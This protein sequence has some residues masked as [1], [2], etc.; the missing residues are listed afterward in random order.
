MKPSV[1][2]YSFGGYT[3]PEMLGVLG[4]MDKAKEL[5]FD[6]FEILDRYFDG[7][8]VTY[9]DVVRHSEKIGL[10]L[11]AYITGAEFLKSDGQG[12]EEQVEALKKH[13]DR[14]AEMGIHLLRH[15]VTHGLSNGMRYGISFDK[16]LPA[17][18]GC[19]R[20]VTE[21]AEK[22]GVVTCFEN[23]GFFTQGS[24]RCEK[25]LEAVAHPNF[26]MLI[27]IGN[28]VCADEDPGQAVGRLAKYAVHVHV[29]DFHLKPG[30]LEHPG[31][32]WNRSR[33]GNYYRG[34]I[35]G[36]GDVYPRRAID[37]LKRNGYDGYVSM[38]F[39][40]LEDNL[41]GI[42]YGLNNLKKYL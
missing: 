38:E 28:F 31:D 9:M 26:G 5:G 7:Y 17:I 40:G 16:V 33:G 42:E 34:A 39:E 11:I 2:I 8:G 30:N 24:E 18:S 20:E 1:S 4:C 15:D 22:K 32:G 36:Q 12:S 23:H 25:L 41:R 21:Y 35:I 29:K 10:P 14:A 37:I 13:I 19:C 6:G 27:D 3:K